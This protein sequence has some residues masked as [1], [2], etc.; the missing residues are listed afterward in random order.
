[1]PRLDAFL[2]Y[3]SVDVSTIKELCRRW[4]PGLQAPPKRECHRALE[5]IRES[6]SELRFYQQNIFKNQV[7]SG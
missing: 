6:I 2:H 4:Y 3:R 5:D 1:M 7:S